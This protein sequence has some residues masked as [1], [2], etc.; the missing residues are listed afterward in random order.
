MARVLVTGGTGFVGSNL[1]L[2]LE[3]QEHEVIILDEKSRDTSKDFKGKKIIQP[4][5]EIVDPTTHYWDSLIGPVDILFHQA[6]ITDTY[7]T[8]IAEM[9]RVNLHLSMDLF[10]LAVKKGCRK[11]VYASSTAVYGDSK[12]PYKEGV[13]KKAPINPYGSSKMALD[14]FASGFSSYHAS[15]KDW[16]DQKVIVVG[17]RYS[18]VYGPREKHKGNMASMIYQLAQQI[19][20]GKN[21]RIFKDG[22]QEREFNYIDDVVRANFLAAEAK[23]SCIVNCGTG[24]PVSFNRIIELLN[25][26]LGTDKKPEYFDNP[27]PKTYQSRIECDMSLAK[28]KIGFEPRFDIESGIKAYFESGFL[29]A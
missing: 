7:I 23:E 16:K 29:T 28:A 9:F 24:K 26:V 21:P 13:T 18:N 6:A 3:K 27:N 4:L 25:K 22:E 2:E 15:N 1:A 14:Q 17:L 5:E 11:I 20:S 8:N 10:E 19:S 12:A